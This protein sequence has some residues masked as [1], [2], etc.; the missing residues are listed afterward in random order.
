MTLSSVAMVVPYHIRKTYP[1]SAVSAVQK[2]RDAIHGSGYVPGSPI[3]ADWVRVRLQEG[4]RR[5][6]QVM[7]LDF[8]AEVL[9]RATIDHDDLLD[10]D[11]MIRSIETALRQPANV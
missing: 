11:R 5:A 2:V 7:C 1:P 9:A 8:L 4:E 3:P 10:Q 6:L